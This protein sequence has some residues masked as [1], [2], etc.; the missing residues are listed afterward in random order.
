MDSAS[1]MPCNEA[2][3]YGVTASLTW[4]LA[5]SPADVFRLSAWD[6]AEDQA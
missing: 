5:A 4:G 1:S 2:A 3:K 6:A